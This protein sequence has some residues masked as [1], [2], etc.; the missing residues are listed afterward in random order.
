MESTEVQYYWVWVQIRWN[1]EHTNQSKMLHIDW[2]CSVLALVLL[3][4][5]Y[6]YE[7]TVIYFP[8][9]YIY[10]SPLRSEEKKVNVGRDG[11]FSCPCHVMIRMSVPWLSAV[12][13]TKQG[14]RYQAND[15]NKK[16]RGKS[17]FGLR[18]LG[19][20]GAD[21]TPVVFVSDECLVQTKHGRLMRFP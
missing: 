17:F 7:M 20:R 6:Q 2:L 16:T 14:E 21:S 11:Q 1:W 10:F 4:R 12:A 8:V 5:V 9:Y 19:A 3:D 15:T 13:D 18:Q